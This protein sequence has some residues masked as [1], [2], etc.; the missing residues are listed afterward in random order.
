MLIIWKKTTIKKKLRV[1]GKHF[2][3]G[4]F[5]YYYWYWL[6]IRKRVLNV[7]NAFLM[8]A[9]FEALAQLKTLLL[10]AVCGDIH[11]QFYDLMK[12]FE[13]GGPPSTTRYLFLGDY[14]DRG[15]FS[16]E[17]KDQESSHVI[18]AISH[19]QRKYDQNKSV[20]FWPLMYSLCK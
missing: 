13:V 4:I 5:I 10:V 14:V 15:Y 19:Y 1:E 11:G 18:W 16:I 2:E 9:Y 20:R 8:K 17:V 12:L 3:G 7:C 6:Y